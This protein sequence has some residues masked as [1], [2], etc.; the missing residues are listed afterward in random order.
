VPPIRKSKIHQGEMD[1]KGESVPKIM[2]TEPDYLFR[3]RY[4]HPN[5]IP[6]PLTSHTPPRCAP[7]ENDARRGMGTEGEQT[8][9]QAQGSSDLFRPRVIVINVDSSS[10]VLETP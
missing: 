5:T 8:G 9:Q 4:A 6:T 7:Q 3:A 10:R 2:S 1:L